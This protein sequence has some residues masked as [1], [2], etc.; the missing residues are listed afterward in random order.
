MPGHPGD[1]WLPLED[2]GMAWKP[3]P[4]IR[5]AIIRSLVLVALV[6]SGVG[7]SASGAVAVPAPACF[8]DEQMLLTPSA[9]TYVGDPLFVVA[10]STYPHA[11]ARFTGPAGPML[12]E[13]EAVGDLHFW[14]VQI[15]ATQPG[16]QTF[17]FDVTDGGT[18]A[19]SCAT[20]VAVILD[21]WSQAGAV[22]PPAGTGSAP[23]PQADAGPPGELGVSDLTATPTSTSRP[24]R[25][26]TPEPTDTPRPT[27]TPR[28]TDTPAPTRTPRPAEAARQADSP[29][30]TDTPRPTETPRPTPTDT[31][32][33]TPTVTPTATLG[34]LSI[35][36]VRPNPAT[37]GQALTI[38]GQNFGSNRREVDGDVTIDGRQASVNA[39]S[40]TEIIVTV[41]VGVQG[42]PERWIELTVAGQPARVKV[43]MNC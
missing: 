4:S 9:T 24:T 11:Y 39:W 20:A 25:T 42:G 32:T 2:T 19:T 43:R 31:R 16:E 3:E 28:P 7:W 38:R 40:N 41:P 30:A 34:P 26:P 14:H 12:A 22:N 33:P 13:H 10:M 17:A 6:V 5:R 35:A 27:R 36:D 29:E 37:C 1:G 15:V 8:G 18:V 23:A 21:S